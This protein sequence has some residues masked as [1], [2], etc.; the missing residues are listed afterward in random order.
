MRG[1]VALK[2]KQHESVMQTFNFSFVSSTRLTVKNVLNLW[3][4]FKNEAKMASR[5]NMTDCLGHGL[6]VV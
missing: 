4:N 2:L 5:A 1:G 3:P 6:C